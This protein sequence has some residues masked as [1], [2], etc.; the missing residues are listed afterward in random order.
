MRPFELTTRWILPAGVHRVWRRL[1][2][3][4]A[5]VGR[6]QGVQAESWNDAQPLVPGGAITWRVNAA[7]RTE[8]RFTTRVTRLD[9]HRTIRIDADGDLEG[10]GECRLGPLD[11]DDDGT[12]RT[13]L[14]FEFRAT[15]THRIPLLLA[16]LP[17]GRR[18]L[19]WGHDRVMEAAR[20]AL[21]SALDDGSL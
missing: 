20:D 4:L 16:R 17:G 11:P 8:L 15:P 18:I 12:P 2:D 14:D 7:Y 9:T 10:H 19:K 21:V 5:L 6:W 3:P 13:Q 1:I